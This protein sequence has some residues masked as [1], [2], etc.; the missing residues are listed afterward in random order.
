MKDSDHSLTL[1]LEKLTR[2]VEYQ[3]KL[4]EK[5]KH[6]TACIYESETWDYSIYDEI[7]DDTWIALDKKDHEK[8]MKSLSEL[9]EIRPWKSPIERR[10]RGR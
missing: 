4:I 7:P 5:Y 3:E 1:Q 6:L 10:L 9:D 8:I 2:K